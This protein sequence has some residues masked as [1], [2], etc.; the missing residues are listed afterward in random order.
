[1]YRKSLRWSSS[2]LSHIHPRRV[3]PNGFNAFH[4]SG[5]GTL[6]LKKNCY[7]RE[8]TIISPLNYFSAEKKTIKPVNSNT[9]P[10]FYLLEGS[11]NI[12]F[13]F[14]ICGTCKSVLGQLVIDTIC[15]TTCNFSDRIDYADLALLDNFYCGPQLNQGHLVKVIFKEYIGILED[16]L[17]SSS[18]G[19]AYEPT[20]T[21]PS[22]FNF[23]SHNPV[24]TVT[25]DITEAV[26]EFLQFYGIDDTLADYIS[27]SSVDT[28]KKELS[29][30]K[31]VMQHFFVKKC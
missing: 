21:S 1:M 8:I 22:V 23:F 30:W 26:S 28:K 31:R 6:V 29:N 7:N 13:P 16:N 20:I 9:T 25:E 11:R 19:C 15:F 12:D 5:T 4:T 27:L 2:E 14:D 18:N 10:F 17:Y 3:P 24:H